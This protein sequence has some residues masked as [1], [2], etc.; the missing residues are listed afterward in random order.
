[1]AMIDI[2]RAVDGEYLQHRVDNT[3]AAWARARLP[4]EIKH[5]YKWFERHLRKANGFSPWN[6]A[7]GIPSA[8]IRGE[9]TSHGDYSMRYMGVLHR[10]VERLNAAL[11]RAGQEPLDLIETRQRFTRTFLVRI[12]SGHDLR[13]KV[14]GSLKDG[15]ARDA[16]NAV[17]A[18]WLDL[19]GVDPDVYHRCRDIVLRIV[20]TNDG[21]QQTYLNS[22]NHASLLFNKPR[23]GD[24]TTV[25]DVMHKAWQQ[26]GI[27]DS[28]CSTRASV[29]R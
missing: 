24:P 7:D 23:G 26:G 20:D 17:C 27:R 18:G 12:T 14:D 1:M 3:L 2:W 6:Y 25:P 9:T 5:T 16:Y 19:A 28:E 22:G 15:D 13:H 21:P 10:S 29:H 8:L 4:L 11:A